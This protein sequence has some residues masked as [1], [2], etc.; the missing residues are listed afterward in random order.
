MRSGEHIAAGQ[1]LPHPRKGLN[2]FVNHLVEQRQQSA[3]AH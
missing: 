1:K 3:T 2:V